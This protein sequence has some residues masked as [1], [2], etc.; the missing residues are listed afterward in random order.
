MITHVRPG[1]IVLLYDR[2]ATPSD[3]A[4][5]DHR[6]LSE[7]LGIALAQLHAIYRFVTVLELLRTSKLVRELW[8]QIGETSQYLRID[9]LCLIVQPQLG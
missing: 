2:I 4:A 1:S 7:A 8:L 6:L 5:V 9:M 3:P